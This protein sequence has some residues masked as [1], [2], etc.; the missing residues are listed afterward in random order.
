MKRTVLAL[1]TTAGLVGA[2]VGCSAAPD[3]GVRAADDDRVKVVA[4]TAVY[5]AI[6]EQIGG[7]HVEVVSIITSPTQDPH[8]YEA[9]ARDRLT[10][11][12]A[13]LI[14]ENGG[15]YD[16]FMTQLREDAGDPFVITAVEFSHDFPGS[17][18]RAHDDDHD[19]HAD[20]DHAH[21]DAGFNEHGAGFNE[22]VWFDVHTMTHVAEAIAHDLSEL[23]PDASDE[24]TS[25]AAALHADLEELEAELEALHAEFEGTGVFVTE[26]VPGYLVV[27][28]GLDDL[29]PAGFATAVEHG[30]DVPPATLLEAIRVIESGRVKLVLTNAQ[31]GGA[32]TQRIEDVAV[33]TGV[34]ILTFTELIPA[35]SSYA[36]WMRAAITDLADALRS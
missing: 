19:D 11:S 17:D 20:H 8:S 9:S 3:G 24:L 31:T 7:E 4:S 25:A 27:A 18:A 6:A 15:G 29:A 23:L 10:V 12:G 34:P 22:H 16:A 26:P 5:G 33:D 14:I 21:R 2:L 35:G 28:A 36:D 32:E 1:A 30:S 13:D